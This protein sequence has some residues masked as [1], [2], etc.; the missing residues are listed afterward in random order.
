MKNNAVSQVEGGICLPIL[1]W[2]CIHLIRPTR[3]LQ[4]QV[5]SS[6]TQILRVI[7]TTPRP[8]FYDPHAWS[9]NLTITQAMFD[10]RADIMTHSR[11]KCM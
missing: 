7:F 9:W 8:S 6:Q 5:T 4:P 2:F 3:K 10:I 1:R 11:L